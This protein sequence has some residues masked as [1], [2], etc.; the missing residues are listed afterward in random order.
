MPDGKVVRINAWDCEMLGYCADGAIGV[1]V[2]TFLQ[3]FKVN[4]G[5][6]GIQASASVAGGGR[7]IRTPAATSHSV[8]NLGIVRP[9]QQC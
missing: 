9:K 7:S 2:G 1:P 3:C 6:I 8:L 5:R 4:S